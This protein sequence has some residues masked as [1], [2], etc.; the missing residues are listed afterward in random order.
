MV[1]RQSSTIPLKNKLDNLFI[2]VIEDIPTGIQKN[3][4]TSEE[5]IF[6]DYGFSF[7]E[8]VGTGDLTLTLRKRFLATDNLS[9]VLLVKQLEAYTEEKF[10]KIRVIAGNETD[11]YVLDREVLISDYEL[12]PLG[13]SLKSTVDYVNV[14]IMLRGGVRVKISEAELYLKDFGTMYA[15]N[16]SK[17]VTNVT[18]G[19]GV[20][21][22]TYTE[23]FIS[24][25]FDE[26]SILYDFS[27]NGK[28]Q[29]TSA[30]T[31][32]GVMVNQ[33]YE[34]NK[35]KSKE[36][37]NGLGNKKLKQ[38]QEFSSDGRKVTKVTD[39]LGNQTSYSY[40]DFERIIRVTNALNEQMDYKYFETGNISLLEQMLLKKDNQQI[41]VTYT[42]ES[43]LIKTLTLT[44]G[45]VYEYEYD[46]YKNIKELKL[47][48]KII[49]SYTYDKQLLK[50]IKYGEQGDTYTFDYTNNLLS[51]I[52]LNGAIKYKYEYNDKNQLSKV[53]D[54]ENK[55]LEWYTYDIDGKVI[56]VETSVSTIEY[57]YDNLGQINQLAKDINDRRIYQ[58][59][60][61]INRSKGSHPESLESMIQSNYGQFGTIFLEDASIKG[62]SGI[63]NPVSSNIVLG[64]EGVIPYIDISASDNLRYQITK[65][66]NTY[67]NG[68]VAF[69]FKPTAITELVQYLLNLKDRNGS[70]L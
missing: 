34:N 3:K 33:E 32:Y 11:T 44:N 17:D 41:G 16:E 4:L 46:D 6:N 60:E 15:Y 66:N 38:S 28:G 13:L 47:N 36:I 29:I 62:L 26:S 64:K 48:N 42:Y 22:Y 65:Y 53:L 21:D 70:Y 25:S 10:V 18:T 7:Y 2:D 59:Y 19:Y 63:I 57:G 52:S 35:V 55:A 1:K 51:V 56:K 9:L 8:L 54:D 20:K 27:R 43:G 12:I 58:S 37:S 50:S 68:S 67:P 45:S 5:G 24:S 40:D 69:W 39:E 61:T 30:K 14:V 49:C 31:A 23:G